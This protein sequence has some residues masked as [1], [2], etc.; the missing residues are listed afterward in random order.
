MFPLSIFVDF[1]QI[2][3]V[4][5]EKDPYG[6]TI[7]ELTFNKSHLFFWFKKAILFIRAGTPIINQEKKKKQLGENANQDMINSH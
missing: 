2:Y 7:S 5:V 1:N 4:I 6:Q 3:T